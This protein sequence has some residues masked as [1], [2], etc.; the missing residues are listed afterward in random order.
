MKTKW[1]VRFSDVASKWVITVAGIGTIA[2]VFLVGAFLIWVAA[3]LFLGASV[4]SPESSAAAWDET[5]LVA[6][7]IDEFKVMGYAAY[8]DGKVVNFR[9]DTGEKLAEQMLFPDKE[10]VSFSFGVGSDNQVAVGFKDGSVALGTFEFVTEFFD[11]QDMDKS[12]HDMA[13]GETRVMGAGMVQKTPIGQY[14][15]Q[16]LSVSFDDPVDITGGVPIRVVDKVIRTRGPM[17]AVIDEAGTLHVKAIRK[18]TNLLTRKVTISTTGGSMKVPDTGRGLPGYVKI[19]GL[20]ENVVLAWDTGEAIRVLTRDVD[21]L[22]IVQKDIDLTPEG[23][24][25]SALQFIIGRNTLIVGTDGGNTYGFFRVPDDDSPDNFRL[26]LAQ[27]MPKADAPVTSLTSS[28][29]QRIFGTGYADGTVKIFYMTGA[30]QIAITDAGDDAV[31]ALAITP[32]DDGLFAVS[33][34]TMTRWRFDPRYPE[35]SLTSLFTPVWYEGYAEPTFVWQSSSATDDAEPK[36]SLIPLIVGTLKAT[37]YALLFGVP[38]ALLAA[39]YT[40]EFMKPWLK[41]KVKPV[42]ELMASLPSVVLGFLAGLVIAPFVENI[43]PIVIASLATIPLACLLGA[44]VW[45]MIPQRLTLPN[46]SIRIVF[47]SLTLPLGIFLA[48]LLGGPVEWLLFGGDIKSWID[49]LNR[50]NPFGSPVG[51]WVVALLPL[52]ALATALVITRWFNPWLREKDTGWNRGTWT[53][54][55]LLKFLG[56]LVITITLAALVGSLLGAVGLDIRGDFVLGGIDVAPVDTYVQRNAMIVGFAMGFAIIPIIYTISEDALSSV[57]DQLRSASLGSGATP[58]QTATRVI[59]PTAMSGL[60]SALMIGL[61]RAVGETM[62]VLMALG[63]TPLL[64][65]NIFNGAR[66]LSANLAVELPEAVINSTHYRTLFLA[67]LTLF[68]MT[69][70][71]NTLAERIRQRF[72]KRAV[73]L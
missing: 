73:N 40:S 64:D 31:Q 11:R 25:I 32:K 52:C 68:I 10:P 44:Y 61:G 18:K 19:T 23:D 66:T 5:K 15:L 69:F 26:T 70:I 67:A 14:R 41:S 12:Y 45:Q 1:S 3:P 33:Q 8:A 35:A 37:I 71:V 48:W 20:G 62:I 9:A 34:D 42:V 49:G 17:L 38:L 65:L 55:S 2:A 28:A 7:E 54:I 6:L 22:A 46:E 57:P 29:R 47:I 21:E 13:K 60:F 39:I 50:D 4:D 58:W 30:N 63:N 43:V 24:R 16:R 56:G 72:R 59:V 51:G 36:L 27:T 53:L